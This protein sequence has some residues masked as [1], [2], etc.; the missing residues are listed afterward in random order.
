VK[1][2]FDKNI[3]SFEVKKSS[4]PYE[5]DS[6][7]ARTKSGHTRQEYEKEPVEVMIKSIEWVEN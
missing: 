4:H 3:K 6:V 5:P 1:D 7:T 2:W